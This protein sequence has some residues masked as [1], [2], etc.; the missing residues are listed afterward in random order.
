MTRKAQQTQRD[1]TVMDK[2]REEVNE[3]ANKP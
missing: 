3:L 2:L 1:G